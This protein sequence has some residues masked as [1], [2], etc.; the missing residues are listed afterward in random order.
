MNLIVRVSEVHGGDADVA[1]V[2]FI[3]SAS[4][5]AIYIHGWRH[6]ARQHGGVY[7]CSLPV[8]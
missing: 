5:A 7:L 3:Y 8:K 4:V 2:Q 6:N 1:S